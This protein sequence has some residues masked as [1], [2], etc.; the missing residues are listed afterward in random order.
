MRLKKKKLHQLH[1]QVLINWVNTMLM[2]DVGDG[3]RRQNVSVTNDSILM[4]DV[5]DGCWRQ[6]VLKTKCVG[7]KL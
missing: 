5:G 1:Q 2:T 3:C 7:D 4:T 6:N